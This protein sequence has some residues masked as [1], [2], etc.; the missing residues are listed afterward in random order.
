M[1]SMN[2]TFY[3]MLFD[4]SP[5]SLW[6]EDFSTVMES[7]TQLKKQGVTDLRAH[8]HTY[9]DQFMECIKKLKVVDV[10]NTSLWLF[11]AKTKKE[12]LDNLH[13][14]FKDEAQDCLMESVI[15]LGEDR[16]YFDGYGINYDLHGNKLYFNISWSI[17]GGE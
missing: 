8:F 16:K 4:Q 13:L 14:V 9:P 1:N 17:T 7:L 3:R 15:A 12:L 10:N 6:V 5:V 11:K 2:Q